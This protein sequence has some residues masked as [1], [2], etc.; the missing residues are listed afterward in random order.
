MSRTLPQPGAQDAPNYWTFETGG[1]LR[2][3]IERY[4][5]GE[6]LTVRDLYLIKAYLKQWVDSPAWEANPHLTPEGVAQLSLLRAKVSQ[7][8]TAPQLV[9]CV[10]LA[11]E[12]GMNPL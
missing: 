7:A 8:R 1:E 5:C 11:G 12:M 10:E 9:A 3:A 6:E 2:P 4:I